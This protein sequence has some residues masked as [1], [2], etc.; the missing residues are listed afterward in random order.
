MNGFDFGSFIGADQ[1]A[2][3]VD[4]PAKQPD[5][6]VVGI[7]GQ[8]YRT[9][10]GGGGLFKITIIAI[11]INKSTCLQYLKST[12]VKSKDRKKKLNPTQLLVYF[13]F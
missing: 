10:G 3:D 1:A 11:K 4:G 8:V 2:G 12:I 13:P 9:G 6:L 7:E 5:S